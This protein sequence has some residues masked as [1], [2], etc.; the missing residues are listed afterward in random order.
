MLVYRVLLVVFGCCFGASIRSRRSDLRATGCGRGGK[1]SEGSWD[2]VGTVVKPIVV[3][4]W[5]WSR[6]P[7]SEGA[8]G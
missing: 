5:S 2:E 8:G 3:G 1:D 7:S 4:L 6:S